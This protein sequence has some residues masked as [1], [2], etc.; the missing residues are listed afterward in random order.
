MQHTIPEDFPRDPAMGSVTGVQPKYLARLVDGKYV[1][2]Q[3][4]AERLER[5]QLCLD[6]V[7]Q[8]VAYCRRK[9]GERDDWTLAD[10]LGRVKKAAAQKAHEWS[11]SPAELE[12]ILNRVQV[13]LCVD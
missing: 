6:L 3:T 2:G 12:W 5:Y 7:G 13:S 11:V 1:V 8:L 10:V 4:E 9:T